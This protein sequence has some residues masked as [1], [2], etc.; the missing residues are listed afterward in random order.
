MC[1]GWNWKFHNTYWVKLE[2]SQHCVE[3]IPKG[4][5][6]FSTKPWK[7]PKTWHER[8][9]PRTYDIWHMAYDMGWAGGGLAVFTSLLGAAQS[10]ATLQSP[11]D[12]GT[13]AASPA[14]SAVPKSG[15]LSAPSYSAESQ[16]MS[17]GPPLLP[18]FLYSF[19][20]RGSCVAFTRKLP[21]IISS[22]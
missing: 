18:K 12:Q 8:N 17:K 4:T 2:I 5:L 10:A 1:I 16:L 20:G 14:Y 3:K 13:E 11:R 7:L 9:M 21:K 15:E 6:V 22:W 19:E